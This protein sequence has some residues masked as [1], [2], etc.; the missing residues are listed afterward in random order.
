MTNESTV[1][2][3]Q[4]GNRHQSITTRRQLVFS[5]LAEPEDTRLSLVKFLKSHRIQKRT[6]YLLEGEYKAGKK[7]LG[8]RGEEEHRQKLKATVMDAWDR[9]EGREPPK[10][11]SKGAEITEVSGDER[12]ALERKVYNDAIASDATKGDKELAVR[13][14][15]M[16]I[17]RQEVKV[18]LTAD[19]LTR[20]NLEA[21]RQL[22]EGGYRVEEVQEEP[23]LLSE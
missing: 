3:Q 9:T 20:R 1:Q 2:R 16:L 23:S 12:I 14:L 11:T 10:R 15:G 13:M 21:E 7:A 22:R 8:K 19:E 18:G 17:E 6:F 4:Y 5:Y